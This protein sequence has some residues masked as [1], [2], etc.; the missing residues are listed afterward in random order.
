MLNNIVQASAPSE[1]GRFHF[2]RRIF[3]A[4][5]KREQIKLLL[6]EIDRNQ[7]RLDS[8]V[9]KSERVPKLRSARQAVQ[10]MSPHTR[11]RQAGALHE[12]LQ[13]VFKCSKHATHIARLQLEAQGAKKTVDVGAIKASPDCLRYFASRMKSTRPLLMFRELSSCSWQSLGAS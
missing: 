5:S 7:R 1:D 13:R 9:S 11:R 10:A 2:A 8:A 3:F 12:A 4:V 6:E